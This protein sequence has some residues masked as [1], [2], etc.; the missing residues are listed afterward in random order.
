[1]SASVVSWSAGVCATGILVSQLRKLLSDIHS[2]R[3]INYNI[4]SALLSALLICNFLLI[5]LYIVSYFS[6]ICIHIYNIHI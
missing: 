4:L 3:F 1:M 6:F 2:H 5:N